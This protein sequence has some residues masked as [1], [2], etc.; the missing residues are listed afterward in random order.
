MKIYNLGLGI[1]PGKHKYKGKYFDAA[2]AKFQPQ[3]TTPYSVEI[4]DDD[5][6]AADALVYHPDKKLDLIV[7]DLEKI[8][9][10]LGRVSN[11]SERQA[12][13]EAQ[14][15]LEKEIFLCDSRLE[16]PTREMLRT[17]P[18]VSMKPSLQ[19]EEAGDLDV[20]IGEVLNRA[21]IILFFTAGKK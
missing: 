17:L 15:S 12:L 9:T 2:V 4:I 6:Q 5:P 10:R 19:R 21:G 13:T 1:E 3:K 16:E 7:G 8:E 14:K 18:L 11:E 20:L